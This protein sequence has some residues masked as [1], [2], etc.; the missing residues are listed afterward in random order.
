MITDNFQF[1]KKLQYRNLK[2]HIMFDD[3][4]FLTPRNIVAGD[5]ISSQYGKYI[6][7]L[8]LDDMTANNWFVGMQSHITDSSFFTGFWTIISVD[9]VAKKIRIQLPIAI[10]PTIYD[11]HITPN[12]VV[13]LADVIDGEKLLNN[14]GVVLA[15]VY[16]GN[17]SFVYQQIHNTDGRIAITNN[18]AS[19]ITM[20][21]YDSFDGYS[22]A[23]EDG[24]GN[25]SL[26]A[27]DSYVVDFPMHSYELYHRVDI[28]GDEIS[29]YYLNSPI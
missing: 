26:V 27:G 12:G 28:T 23:V 7:E 8:T 10:T 3:T 1:S 18:G 5:L 2:A 14:L 16:A 4:D 25:V 11:G 15:E 29:S 9:T 20:T 19:T 21:F 24:L 17:N 6:W 22:W 13:S